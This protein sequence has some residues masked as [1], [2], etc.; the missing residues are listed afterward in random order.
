MVI[1]KIQDG[2]ALTLAPEGL[3]DTANAPAFD[4]EMEAAT[5]A[6]TNLTVDFAK[7]EYISSSGLRVLL[8]AQKK[9]NTVGT[10]RLINVNDS[11]KEVF[12]LTGFIDI[13]TIV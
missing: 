11:V 10:M 5:N 12:K 13:L 8:K 9:L 1:N 2:D 4:T 7:V 3:L 6:T